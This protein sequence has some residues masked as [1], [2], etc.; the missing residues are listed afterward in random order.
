METPELDL[1]LTQNLIGE[2]C[3]AIKDLLLQKNKAYGNSAIDPVRIFSKASAEEQIKVRIDDKLS[4]ICRGE[5]AG[6]DVIQDLI[7]YF[8]LFR[9]AKR[10]QEIKTQETNS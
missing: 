5:E 2:E 4:R 9:V 6:E 3:D 10:F 8:I 1:R 7:G